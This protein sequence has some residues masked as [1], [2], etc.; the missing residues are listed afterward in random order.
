[1]F[2]QNHVPADYPLLPVIAWQPLCV[3]AD[4]AE[5]ERLR[6]AMTDSMR[7]FNRRG[8]RRHVTRIANQLIDTFAAAG[9]ADLV[10]QFAEHLPLLVA[11]HLF[12][13]PD[14]YGP[15][16]VTACR[17]LMAGTATAQASN[18]F[19]TA[20]MRQ[21][22]AR[23]HA[24]PGADLAS[25]LI[26]HPSNLTDDEIVQ[27]LRFGLLAANENTIILIGST[28]RMMLTDHRFRASLAGGQMTLPD[29]VEQLLWDE[30]PLVVL[31]GRWATGDTELGDQ[32]IREGD[33]LLIGIAAAN[34]DPAIRPDLTV[35]M[36]GN[37]SHLAFSRGPHECP[38][39]DIG[40]A[41][42]ETAIDT[43]LTRLP[44]LQLAVHPSE[45]RRVSSW[46]YRQWVALPVQFQ[47]RRPTPPTGT[48]P[49]TRR[50]APHPPATP[51]ANTDGQTVPAPPTPQPEASWRRILRRLL[52]KE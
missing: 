24:A 29:A 3:F 39:Q 32:K 27:H 23:K 34:T 12:G 37:R 33:M 35:P 25:W 22:V 13:M 38:G 14:E 17:D 18:D 45:L 1:M 47:P 6:A 5:H 9:Q 50:A 28:L 31:P 52:L 4:G 36:H 11:T 19:I 16:L 15:R 48:E 49:P 20:T 51:S 2:Q 10:T 40:R 44:D 41:I 46:M 42:T 43:L 26:E 8:I 30:P 21:L 7:R